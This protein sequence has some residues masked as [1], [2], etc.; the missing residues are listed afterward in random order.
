MELSMNTVINASPA[1]VWAVVSNIEGSDAVISGIEKI[2]VLEKPETGLVG[3]KWK[4]TRT[5]FGKE[6]TEVMWVTDV[7]DGVS[8][9]VRAESHGSVY[10]SVIFLE[11]EGEGT[12][13]TMNFKAT[14]QGFLTKIMAVTMGRLFRGA[15]QK[16][17]QKDLDDIKAA[18]EQK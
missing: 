5:M 18:I 8:Y 11:S 2:E 6:A 13:L 14:P 16:A 3:F 7:K 4:E 10:E 12:K 9:D 17:L 15:T 1:D